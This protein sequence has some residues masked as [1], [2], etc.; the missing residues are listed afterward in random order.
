MQATAKQK[1]MFI[2]NPIAGNGHG[3]KIIPE[4]ESKIS[5][6]DIP[7]EIVATERPGHAIELSA[8][9]AAAGY[10][11]I[12]AVGGDGTMNEVAKSLLDTKG[13]ITG[14]I[15]AGTGNDF[16]QI[17]G[18]P[19]RFE[20][21]H[22]DIFF[23]QHLVMMDYGT[24][25]T[26]PFLNGMGLGFDAEVAAKNYIAPGETKMGG[27]GKYLKAILGTLFFFKE[28]RV[29]VKRDGNVEET[30]CFIN[31]IS[32]GRRYGGGFY[33]TPH[34]IANDGLLDVCM[35]KKLGLLKR[36]DILL[37]ATKGAHTKDRK[38]HYYTTDHLEVDF[39]KEVPFHVDGEVFYAS[40]FDVRIYHAKIPIIFNPEG[41]HFFRL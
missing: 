16:V 3:K 34:A 39:G 27:K 24:C 37:K 28:Y 12:I 41:N 14:I 31:T 21:S 9:C 35:V 29:M 11:H 38:V 13:I 7:G 22:W 17:L 36:L 5:Q 10:T 26:I 4:L 19:D 40:K 6:Y 33:L 32:N 25:N 23:R 2:V 8:R 20:A 1:W 30:D 15:P 18:Y